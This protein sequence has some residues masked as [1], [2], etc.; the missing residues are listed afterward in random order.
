MHN[1]PLDY[2][3]F[4]GL[5][6]PPFRLLPDPAFF[7][8]SDAH[9]KIKDVL[10]YGI[11]RGEGFILLTGEAGTGKSLLLRMIL[12]ELPPEK[13]TALIVAPRVS[14]AGLLKLILEDLGV[15]TGDIQETALLQ[16]MLEAHVV[17]LAQEG[18]ELVIIVDEAQNLPHDTLE[19]LRLMSNIETPK[20]K[21]LQVILIGQPELV[22]LVTSS[23][24]GQLAQRIT[25]N[26]TLR[27]LK[28]QEVKD[29]ILYRLHKSGGG[30]IHIGDPA[31]REVFKASG[32]IPRLVNKIMDRALLV[33]ASRG[34][35]DIS[36][37]VVKEALETLP[38]LCPLPEAEN[39]RRKWSIISISLA[40]SV[41]AIVLISPRLNWH[42]DE[43]HPVVDVQT[44]PLSTPPPKTKMNTNKGQLYAI[45]RTKRAFV[46]EGPGLHYPRF[47]MVAMGDRL[48]VEEKRNGWIRIKVFDSKGMVRHGWIRQDLVI[49]EN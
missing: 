2:T 48:S 37:K 43:G 49:F 25:I 7:F 41:V 42:N 10:L 30:G 33:A 6:E 29:Y 44:S 38:N 47:T 46:R 3:S 19:Q 24:L 16:K 12:Q 14:P 36:Q 31:I 20:K 4:F 1:D 39:G 13:E 11:R 26:E 27:P 21:L 17:E 35:R 32:G 28:E 15:D 9:I 5:E 18:K 40:L 23:S 22:S 8:P 45:V 34:E